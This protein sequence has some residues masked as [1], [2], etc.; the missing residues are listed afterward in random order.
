MG[1]WFYSHME[2]HDHCQHQGFLKQS[3]EYLNKLLFRYPQ[4]LGSFW[5]KEV[6]NKS[7]VKLFKSISAIYL[8]QLVERTHPFHCVK[9]LIIYIL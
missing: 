3:L 9:E 7:V 1:L 2:S 5:S 4:S 6:T 8:S